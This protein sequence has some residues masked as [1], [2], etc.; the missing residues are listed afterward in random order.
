MNGTM[1]YTTLWLLVMYLLGMPIA[2]AQLGE[3]VAIQRSLS[4]ITD[5]IAYVDALNRLA[6]LSYE[7]SADTTFTMRYV[8]ARSRTACNTIKVRQTLSI[9]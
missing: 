9:I 8:R 4:R 2:R 7:T 5:S 6:M 1:K 3:T